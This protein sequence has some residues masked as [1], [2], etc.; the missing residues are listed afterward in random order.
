MHRATPRTVLLP[1]RAV[2][3][4]LLLA[5]S[6]RQQDLAREEESGHVSPAQHALPIPRPRQQQPVQGADAAGT[7]RRRSRRCRRLVL[8][9]Q[10]ALLR[11]QC[12]CLL[13]AAH[14]LQQ[15]LWRPAAHTLHTAHH[16]TVNDTNQVVCGVPWR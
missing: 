12:H 11:Q 7:R 10:L 4:H 5:I 6:W 14:Q 2:A 16:S 9:E 8:C 3:P 15:L 1:V 13:Q